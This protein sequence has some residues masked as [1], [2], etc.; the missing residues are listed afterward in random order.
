MKTVKMSFTYE[1]HQDNEVQKVLLII[2]L[3]ILQ[4]PQSHFFLPTLMTHVFIRLTTNLIYRAT[5]SN[6]LKKNSN[7]NVCRI[8]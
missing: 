5:G 3:H 7:S 2:K 6:K 4:T 8:Q 1:D